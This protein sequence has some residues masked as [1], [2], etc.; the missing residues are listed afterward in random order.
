MTYVLVAVGGAAGSLVRYSLGK[1]ISE[2]SKHS[3]PI[4]TFIIN[5]T[6]ALLLGIVSTIGVSSNIALLLGDGFLGAYT[7]FSTFMYEGFNLFK[8]KE[9]LNAFIYILCT[10]ILGVV[11]YVIGSKIG[12]L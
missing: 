12:S 1:F 3:F 5:I 8:E 9:K 7:T 2:K 6:G 10:L 11:G 4:G